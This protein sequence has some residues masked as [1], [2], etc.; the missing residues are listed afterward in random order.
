[1]GGGGR[2]LGEDA[3]EFSVGRK[4][5]T[6]AFKPPD[7]DPAD[8]S[9]RIYVH[10]VGKAD[11]AAFKYPSDPDLPAFEVFALRQSRNRVLRKL[12]SDDETLDVELLSYRPLRRAVF[13]VSGEQQ[14]YFLKIV[15]P[16]RIEGIVQRHQFMFS[17]AIPVPEVVWWSPTGAMIM[18]ELPGQTMFQAFLDSQVADLAVWHEARERL[19]SLTESPFRR[20]SAIE[21]VDW[22]FS[23]LTLL[24]PNRKMDFQLLDSYLKTQ[25]D[26]ER[27]AA[28]HNL[29]SHGDLHYGQILVSGDGTDI[30]AILD[31]DSF[32]LGNPA[33]DVAA[34]GS[35]LSLYRLS[36]AIPDPGTTSSL[37]REWEEW[38]ENLDSAMASA[39]RARLALQQALLALSQVNFQSGRG[40][41]LVDQSLSLA[42]Q[43]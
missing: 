12:F 26:A 5:F 34:F 2:S 24:Y 39:S 23:A 27:T 10:P 37:E 33:D 18:R 32:G 16:N 8:Y 31:L 19:V 9:S 22:A 25:R 13:R 6:A 38:V 7:V 42:G 21:S 36:S 11:L 41:E 40:E 20:A 28:E 4:G 17:K 15:K 29:P 35:Q 30:S 3:V 14:T 1:M 43:S